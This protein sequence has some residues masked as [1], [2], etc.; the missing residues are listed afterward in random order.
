MAVI[1]EHLA[2]KG[3][4]LYNDLQNESRSSFG[5]SKSIAS[6]LIEV[7]PRFP[8]LSRYTTR[9]SLNTRG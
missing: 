3:L 6:L 9:I 5:S 2:R 8:E 1:R 7:L 4:G